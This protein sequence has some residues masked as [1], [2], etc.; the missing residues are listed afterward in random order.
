MQFQIFWT[1]D[2][3]EWSFHHEQIFTK[4]PRGGTSH[5]WGPPRFRI[6]VQ[7]VQQ[8]KSPTPFK[9]SKHSLE[10]ITSK[11]FTFT[12]HSGLPLSGALFPR[13]HRGDYHESIELTHAPIL[14][15]QRV[16]KEWLN[17]SQTQDKSKNNCAQQSTVDSHFLHRTSFPPCFTVKPERTTNAF[18]THFGNF[19]QNSC[20]CN[21]L[22]GN[23]VTENLKKTTWPGWRELARRKKKLA[24]AEALPFLKHT[25]QVKSWKG[26]TSENVCRVWRATGWNYFTQTTRIKTWNVEWNWTLFTESE[27]LPNVAPTTCGL[28]QLWRCQKKFTQNLSIDTFVLPSLRTKSLA[29]NHDNT[30]CVLQRDWPSAARA[31]RLGGDGRGEAADEADWLVADIAHELRTVGLAAQVLRRHSHLV[32]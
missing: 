12:R 15:S 18:W 1:S 19:S 14:S 23:S 22:F 9:T 16:W 13:S 6:R 8:Y 27:V 30:G 25:T 3:R 29:W 32:E 5:F 20:C 11:S 26:N 4:R 7:P 28:R 21:Q 17:Q 2:E 31:A 24:T 10:S